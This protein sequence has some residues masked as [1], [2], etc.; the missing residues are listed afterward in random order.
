MDPYSKLSSSTEKGLRTVMFGVLASA[1]LAT[2]KISAGILGHSYALIAD[3][4][5]SML[6]IISSL[7]VWGSL[8]VAVTPPDKEHPYGHGKVEP[9][10]ALV[11]AAVLLAAAL[12]IAIQS[13][14]EILAPQLAPAPFTLFVLIG[15]VATKETMFQILRRTGLAIGST[16]IETDAW[17]HRSD[18][19]TSVAAFIGISIALLGG[20]GYEMADDWAALAACGIIAFNGIRLFTAAWGDVLDAAP[21]LEVEQRIRDI[22]AGVDEV[23]KI[24]KCRV[25]KSGLGIFVDIHVVVD[26]AV[27]VAHGHHIGHHVKDTLL[28][29]DLNILDVVVHVEPTFRDEDSGGALTGAL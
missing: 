26:G 24:D 22:S 23:V 4:I 18:A 14:R 20:P 29:T 6:D 5:E 25:R 7:V 27:T 10:A 16:A 1:L 17:H 15:V 12:G 8:K 28:A 13:V 2:V 11:V 21:P 3:G 9:L 19:L